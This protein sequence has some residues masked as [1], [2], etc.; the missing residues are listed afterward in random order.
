MDPEHNKN[1]SFN[2]STCNISKIYDMLSPYLIPLLV[3]IS[4]TILGLWIYI[5]YKKIQR[6]NNNMDNLSLDSGFAEYE[7]YDAEVE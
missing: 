3:G 7:V 6:A 4:C 1:N 5:A 2:K